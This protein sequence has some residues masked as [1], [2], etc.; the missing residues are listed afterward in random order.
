[1][2]KGHIEHTAE[3]YTTHGKVSVDQLKDLNAST[4]RVIDT[5]VK[6]APKTCPLRKGGSCVGDRCALF[7]G[8]RCALSQIVEH[9][10]NTTGKICP[11]NGLKCGPHCGFFAG[12]GC[13]LASMCQ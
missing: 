1:M 2:R 8:Q 10:T 13:P 6:D 12:G 5:S 3:I 4:K 11:M 7:C 9:V